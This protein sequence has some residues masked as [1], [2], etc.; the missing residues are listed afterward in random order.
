MKLSKTLYKYRK[1]HHLT[2]QQLAQ[3]LH[4]SRKTISNWENGRSE[5]SFEI[6]KTL[7]HLYN[8]STDELLEVSNVKVKSD[9]DN[10]TC[11]QAWIKFFKNI[12]RLKGKASRKEYMYI[13]VPMTIISFLVVF[14]LDPFLLAKDF[15]LQAENTVNYDELIMTL[16]GFAIVFVIMTLIEIV[17]YCLVARRNHDIGLSSWVALLLFVPQLGTFYQLIIMFVPTNYFKSKK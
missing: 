13:M 11:K 8:V 14:I 10:I 15:K 12:F 16:V 9:N 3:K 5:P 6:L 7:S 4:V 17:L 2:Q 1:A